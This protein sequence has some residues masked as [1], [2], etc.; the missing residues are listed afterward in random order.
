MQM[1]LIDVPTM[2]EAVADRLRAMIVDGSLAPGERL[3][4]E[5]MAARLGVSRTPL[6]E[7]LTRLAG[8]GALT[9]TARRGFFVRPLSVEEL[10]DIYP[11]RALLDPEALRLAGVPDPAQ[12]ATLERMNQAMGRARSVEATI[13]CDNAF[14]LELVRRCPNRELVG[15]IEHYM[16]RTARYEIPL[17]RERAN[18]RHAMA[19]NDE[20]LA[21]LGRRDLARGCAILRRSMQGGEPII[22]AWLQSRGRKS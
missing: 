18:V 3:R 7:A 6:R 4:E 15:L 17:M 1:A 9:N 14:H 21:A 10:R 16:R 13:D 19:T 20:L 12:L 5:E 11:M 22:E 8:E 2:S